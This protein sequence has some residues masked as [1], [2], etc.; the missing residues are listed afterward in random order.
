MVTLLLKNRSPLNPAD[1]EGYTPLHHA[2]AEGH[3]DTAVTLLKEGADFTLKNSAGE[4]ALDLA[5]DKEVCISL[6]YYEN[7]ILGS[8]LVA[9]LYK[10]PSN[11]VS[12]STG[13]PIC[14]TRCGA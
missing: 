9:P 1:N 12:L 13:T 14:F 10:P 11:S 6:E 5:P 4:L 2:I 3:G 7:G 8:L